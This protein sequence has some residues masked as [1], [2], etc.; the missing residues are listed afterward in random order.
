MTY[1]TSATPHPF[2]RADPRAAALLAAALAAI[3][4]LT[5]LA[6]A[7]APSSPGATAGAGGRIALVVDAGA[8]P[9]TALASA[10]ATAARTERAGAA[11]VA[12]RVPRTATE[13]NADVRYFA[14]QGFDTV[15]AVGPLARR[16]A[17]APGA[18]RVI[19]PSAVPRTLR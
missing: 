7:S 8:R 5:V 14:A 9:E 15:V 16:A 4:A 1:S 19:T 12:V 3:V 10:G 2:R 18:M 17:R 6:I 13:A 11:T